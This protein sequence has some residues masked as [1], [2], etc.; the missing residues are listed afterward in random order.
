MGRTDS[1]TRRKPRREPLPRILIVCEGIRTE[2][3]YF[4]WLGRAERIPIEISAGGTPKALVG[5]AVKRKG[6]ADADGRRF[7]DPNLRFDEV[8]CVFDVDEHPYLSEAKRQAAANQIEVAISNPC[9]ELRVLLHFREQT[10]HVERSKVRRA[11]QEILP[12]YEKNLPCD[13]LLPGYPEALRRAKNLEK[14]NQAMNRPNGNP[15]SGVFV[16]VERIKSFRRRIE[17]R[18]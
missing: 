4:Q 16:L 10:A 14:T 1:L 6:E 17:R 3:G 9:F 12:G 15:S 8:W 7:G 18:E 5:K 2:K 13:K 11:C